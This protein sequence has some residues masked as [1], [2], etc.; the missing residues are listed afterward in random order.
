MPGLHSKILP[1]G[2]KKRKER[3]RSWLESLPHRQALFTVS[4]HGRKGRGGGCLF[5]FPLSGHQ[6]PLTGL[7]F[8]TSSHLSKTSSD[9]TTRVSNSALGDS[10]PQA[11]QQRHIGQ[12][13]VDTPL[14]PNHRGGLWGAHWAFHI[15]WTWTNAVRPMPTTAVSH[16]WLTAGRICFLL[17]HSPSRCCTFYCPHSLAFSGWKRCPQTSIISISGDRH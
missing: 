3:L 12:V 14:P 5:E 9:A 13:C 1:P 15:L 11:W 7:D 16:S 17:V 8:V 2:T 4:S 10:N 6:S